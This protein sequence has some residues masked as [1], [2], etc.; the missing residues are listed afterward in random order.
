MRKT[1]FPLLTV[2]LLS[3]ILSVPVDIVTSISSESVHIMPEYAEV[4][5]QQTP[6]TVV[7]AIAASFNETEVQTDLVNATL[8][9][10]GNYTVNLNITRIN[11]PTAGDLNMSVFTT[12][13]IPEVG[14]HTLRVNEISLGTLVEQVFNVMPVDI[15]FSRDGLTASLKTYLNYTESEVKGVPP[16]LYNY[17]RFMVNSTSPDAFIPGVTIGVRLNNTLTETLNN[18]SLG[19]SPPN[20]L[21]FDISPRNWT[22]GSLNSS[23]SKVGFFNITTN[24]VP[25]GRYNITYTLN[26]TKTNVPQNIT[27]VIPVGIFLVKSTWVQS[28][29]TAIVETITPF[30]DT[31]TTSFYNYTTVT[32]DDNTTLLQWQNSNSSSTFSNSTGAL[33]SPF[34]G[35]VLG[36]TIGIAAEGVRQYFAGERV[37]VGKLLVAAGI[38]AITSIIPTT[39]LGAGFKVVT[40]VAKATGKAYPIAAKVATVAKIIEKASKGIYEITK[41][42]ATGLHQGIDKLESEAKDTQNQLKRL[43]MEKTVGKVD[44][45]P[46]TRTGTTVTQPT[47]VGGVAVPIDKLA[48][49]AP[50]IGLAST[51]MIGAVATAIYVKRV[52][53]RKEKQ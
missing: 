6:Y 18:V 15:L 16:G 49:L 29:Q 21:N 28:N 7:V 17:T 14:N 3:S 19:L 35:I 22:Y 13:G 42:A 38:G 5:I 9:I 41:G 34:W 31:D 10:Y 1:V 23:S 48:L 43:Y 24:N 46:T 33:Q 52:K 30:N 27:D 12:L 32:A 53:R 47:S 4:E 44:A 8:D 51:A 25:V 20:G 36:A 37:H 50:Y 40:A 2:I 39:V 26:Y 11:G 45:V